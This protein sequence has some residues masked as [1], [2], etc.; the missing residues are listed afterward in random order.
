MQTF[1][2]GPHAGDKL[3]ER[4]CLTPIRFSHHR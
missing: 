1:A 3:L 2:Y 4:L